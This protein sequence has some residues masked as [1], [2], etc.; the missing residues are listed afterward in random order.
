MKHDRPAVAIALIFFALSLQGIAHGQTHFRNH[1]A[2]A[3]SAFP[4]YSGMGDPLPVI[5]SS[6]ADTASFIDGQTNMKEIDTLNSASNT[7][8]PAGQLGPLFNN[9]SCAACHS[10]PAIGGGGLN[11][12][13][14]RLS[15][16]GPP[17][18]IFAVD[19]MLMQ[20]PMMQNEN[21]I[22]SNGVAAATL[23]GQIG[24]RSNTAS[25]C[26]Q[27]EIDRGFNWQLPICI[28]GSSNDTGLTGTPTC[29]AHRESLPIYGDGLVEATADSTFQQIAAGQDPSIR[30]S[31]RMIVELNQNGTPSSEVSS[32]T[33]T[34]LAR[35]HVGRFGWKDAHSSL[36][37][38]AADAYL[39]EIGITSDLNKDPNTTCAM[40]LQQFGVTLQAADDPEDTVDSTGRSDID[41]FADFMRGLQPPPPG[42]QNA[43]AQAGHQL[44][45]QINCSGCHVESITTAPNPASFVPPTVHGQPL[46]STMNSALANVT[47]HPFGDFLMHDMGGLGDGVNDNG[48]PSDVAGP[49]MIRTMPLWGIR[50]RDIYLHDGRATDVATAIKLHDGQGKA[51]AQAFEALTPAQQQQIVDFIE[52]L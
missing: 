3:S 35:P 51:A 46:T 20:G 19:N 28:P 24:L 23:G 39:N 34:A 7:S 1:K 38:F 16:G 13:E 44:F 43:D 5:L 52:T 9:T 32:A 50:A 41:R 22:F 31:A 21:E 2:S 42:P 4:T 48:S 45:D 18:R 12:F 29:V 37:A 49:T 10:N 11:L 6:P 17:V 8:G 25:T 36:L 30:G 33:L 15:S 14:Q 26:Q 40:G 47:F 27:T